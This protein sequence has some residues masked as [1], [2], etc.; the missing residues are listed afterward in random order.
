MRLVTLL[1]GLAIA[2][3]PSP[4]LA[5]HCYHSPKQLVE[6]FLRMMLEEKKPRAAF[7]AFVSKS[8]IE[9]NPW[10]D[11][12]LE[13]IIEFHEFY[14]EAVPDERSQIKR[15]MADGDLIIVHRQSGITLSFPMGN[16]VMEIFR[17][18]QCKIVE[19]WDVI[20][21]VPLDPSNPHGMF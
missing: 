10:M 14:F 12:D 11:G 9:H 7:E 18:E 13:R 16:A 21:P 4:A 15:L 8:Y 1:T 2:L 19:H 5:E 6:A 3:L 17:V 20:Q